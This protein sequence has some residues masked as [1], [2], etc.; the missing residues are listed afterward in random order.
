MNK[1]LPSLKHF[2]IL[3][4][5]LDQESTINTAYEIAKSGKFKVHASYTGSPVDRKDIAKYEEN[6]WVLVKSVKLQDLDEA[7]V[8][9]L[10]LGT[11]H[12]DLTPDELLR[13]IASGAYTDYGNLHIDYV[14]FT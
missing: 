7:Y 6:A 9:M 13:Y 8:N 5:M 10:L 14:L 1:T 4:I 11:D 12:E 3:V 2:V